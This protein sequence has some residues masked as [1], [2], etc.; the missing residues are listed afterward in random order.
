[1]VNGT[2][3]WVYQALLEEGDEHAQFC[4]EFEEQNARR[5]ASYHR[6]SPRTKRHDKRS[7]TRPGQEAS[8]QLEQVEREK[9]SPRESPKPTKASPST[10][11]APWPTE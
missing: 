10:R 3:E 9:G 1:M 8:G 7:R 4:H 11:S 6:A 5:A 2:R